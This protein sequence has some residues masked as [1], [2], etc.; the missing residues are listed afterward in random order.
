MKFVI[1]GGGTGGHIFP[2]TAVADS[3]RSSGVTAQEILFVG[4]RRGQ[5]R[6]LLGSRDERLILLPGRGIRR[7]V[8]P[9]AL[10]NNTGAAIRVVWSVVVAIATTLQLR[11]EVIV[12]VGGYAAFP[13]VLA[14]ALLRRPMVFIELDASMGLVHRIFHRSARRICFGIAPA[15]LPTRGMV[16]GVPLR[17]SIELISRDFEKRVSAATA[18]GVDPQRHIVVVMTGSLGSTT[19]NNAVSQLAELWADR[20]DVAIVHVTGKRDFDQMQHRRPHSSELQYVLLPFADAMSDLWTLA[21]T[22]ICRAG[23]TTV[24][25]LTFLGIPSILVPLPNAPGD[26]QTMNARSV[27]DVGGARMLPDDVCSANSLAAA[28]D[29]LLRDPLLREQ[30]GSAAKNMGRPDAARHIA[31]VVQA[32]AHGE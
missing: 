27:V 10:W 14:G 25:E 1:T 7:S 8:T 4:S 11:P 5:E 32:V 21:D 17:P 20:Q 22:A 9:V 30:M 23:A 26:H 24:A 29:D 31:R 18:V 3:L 19:V 2:M 12:S 16:T 15:S 13:M 6:A 28:I